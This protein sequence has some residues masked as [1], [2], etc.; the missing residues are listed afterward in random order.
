MG[1]QSEFAYNF[2]K[3]QI[4]FP[5]NQAKQL[6]FCFCCLFLNAVCVCVGGGVGRSTNSANFFP[7]D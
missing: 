4:F 7:E 3:F 1:T 6:S 2:Q 5:E